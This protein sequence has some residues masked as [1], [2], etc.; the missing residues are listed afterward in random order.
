[1]GSKEQR[2]INYSTNWIL[3]EIDLEVINKTIILVTKVHA[4][5]VFDQDGEWI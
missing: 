1:M 3:K 2:T 4:Q 5:K